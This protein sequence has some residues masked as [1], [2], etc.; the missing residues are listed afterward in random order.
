M[1][2]DQK[3][4]KLIEKYRKLRTDPSNFDEGE[5]VLEAAALLQRSGRVSR[6]AIE[7]SWYL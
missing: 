7:V 6:K 3:Y 5:R 1:T 2:D 4:V